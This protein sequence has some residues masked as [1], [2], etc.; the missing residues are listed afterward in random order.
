MKHIIFIATEFNT[1]HW[2][3]F[4]NTEGYELYRGVVFIAVQ[5][6]CPAFNFKG[7]YDVYLLSLFMVHIRLSMFFLLNAKNLASLS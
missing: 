2:H 1:S 3:N 7:V 5:L 4:Q 6:N